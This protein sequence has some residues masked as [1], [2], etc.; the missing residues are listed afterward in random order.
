[1]GNEAI[2]QS[3]EDKKARDGDGDGSGDSKGEGEDK[4]IRSGNDNS[5]QVEGALLA[6][7]SQH[8][9]QTQRM[10]NNALPVLSRPCT[11]Y[12]ERPYGV[13]RCRWR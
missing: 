1:L 5:T 11:K 13:C 3:I 8:M 4:T 7:G 9:R 12:P 10:Q 6:G 2:K